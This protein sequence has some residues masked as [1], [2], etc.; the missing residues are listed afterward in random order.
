MGVSGTFRIGS[1]KVG[2]AEQARQLTSST[3]HFLSKRYSP[4]QT[5]GGVFIQPISRSIGK[6]HARGVIQGELTACF[7]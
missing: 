7:L 1:A 2:G 4:K 5:L 6:R 3:V